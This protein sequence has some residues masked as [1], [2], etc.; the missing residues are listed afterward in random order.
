M[1]FFG[2]GSMKTNIATQQGETQEKKQSIKSFFFYYC[3]NTERF[4]RVFLSCVGGVIFRIF[5]MLQN[6]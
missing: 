1:P 3:A 4:G 6:V 2:C 5:R